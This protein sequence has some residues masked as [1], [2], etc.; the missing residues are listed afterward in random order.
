[1]S[2]LNN[3]KI[4]VFNNNYPK[5]HNQKSAKLLAVFR[6][7]KGELLLT[8]MLDLV[9]VDTLKDDGSFFQLYNSITYMLLLFQGDKG[10]MFSTIR[11]DTHVNQEHYCD[12]IGD[13]F[14]I[15]VVNGGFDG[16]G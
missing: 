2:E 12:S 4:I 16:Q 10:I 6:D 8:K 14:D 13:V 9:L 11:K 1:M 3:R 15:V 5:L 7:I